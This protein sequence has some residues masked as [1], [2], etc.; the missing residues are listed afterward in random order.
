MKILNEIVTQSE[1]LEPLP[2]TA[3]KLARIVADEKSTINDATEIIQY[4][5]ALAADVLRIANSAFSASSRSIGNVRDAVIRLGSG[6]ILEMLV[7][8][9]VKGVMKQ[10]L[11]QYGY[12]EEDLW[13]HSVAS[14][15]AAEYLNNYVDVQI[16]GVSVT[17]AL[18]HD[19]GKLIMVRVFPESNMQKIWKMMDEKKVS[20]AF[21]EKELYG[22]THADVGAHIAQLW[23]LPEKIEHAI[24]F[25][26]IDNTDLDPVTD[27]VRIANIVS[28]AIG[29]GI[30]YEGMSVTIDSDITER[31][32]LSRQNFERLCADTAQKLDAVLMLYENS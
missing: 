25:H 26:H 29:Q 18:L 16:S 8:K 7:S 20:W 24:R 31:L 15:I 23:K 12:T 30:G 6:R 5:Q 28:R 22:F 1:K 9:K 19:I 21:A 2:P 27:S 3:S 10:P 11:S 32:K 14:A 17:A 4:D 13:R